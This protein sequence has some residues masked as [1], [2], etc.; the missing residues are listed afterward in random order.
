MCLVVILLCDIYTNTWKYHYFLL[1]SC[2]TTTLKFKISRHCVIGRL[3][4]VILMIVHWGYTLTK[5]SQQNMSEDTTDRLHRKSQ[6]SS[7]GRRMVRLVQ[8]MSFHAS[9]L[10]Y[11]ILETKPFIEYLSLTGSTICCHL[12]FFLYGDDGR[13]LQLP[14][15]SGGTS[16][17]RDGAKLTPSFILCLQSFS[18]T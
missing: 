6:Q 5:D 7:L 15:R 14:R 1:R 17:K 11:W 16:S 10:L 12:F 18:T 3:K 4:S 9:V 8:E 13:H 2:S